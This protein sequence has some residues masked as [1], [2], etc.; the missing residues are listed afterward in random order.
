MKAKGISVYVTGAAVA[1]FFFLSDGDRK[2]VEGIR[3]RF[4][5]VPCLR[6]QGASLMDLV[7][8]DWPAV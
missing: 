1:C 8:Q 6:F 5:G 4:P 2:L 3:E 7:G